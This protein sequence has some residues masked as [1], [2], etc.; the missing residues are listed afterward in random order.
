LHKDQNNLKDLMKRISLILGIFILNFAVTAQSKSEKF[1]DNRN[2]KEKESG[3][4]LW[5]LIRQDN[6]NG[7]FFYKVLLNPSELKRIWENEPSSFSIRIP[8]KGG[9][10]RQMTFIKSNPT[11]TGFC[12]TTSDG[13][14]LIGKEYSGLHYRVSGERDCK[15]AGISFREDGL[16]GLFGLPSCNISIGEKVPG[17]GDYTLSYDEDSKMPAWD[18]GASEMP[19]KEIGKV[20]APSDKAVSPIC[21][22]VRI[23]MEGD[24]D[25]YTKSGNSLTT[26][27]NF[28]TGLF[29]VV[30]QVY[31]NE[32]ISIRLAS[33][34][35]WT[36][37][38]PYVAMT[39]S[40]TVL[41]NFV[42]NRVASTV[43]AD[44]IHLLSTRS[45]YM[46]G[47]AYL[48]VLCNP[49]YKHGFSNIY[50]QYSALPAYSWSVYCIS[51]ELGH[52]FGSNHTQW[53]GWQLT[54][55]KT[56]RI[57]SCYASEG[58]CGTNTK[59]R[60]GTIMSYCHLSSGIDFNKGFGPL[61]Q[62]AIRNGLNAAT[63]ITSSTCMGIPVVSADSLSNKNN[64]YVLS[65]AI[66]AN[67]NASSWK[68]FEG[69]TVIRSGTLSGTTAFNSTVSIS[70]KSNGT[71]SYKMELSNGTSTSVSAVI[72]VVVSVPQAPIAGG[73]CSATGLMAWF[74]TDGKMRFRF[75]ISS[76][77]TTYAVQV[78]RYNLSNSAIIPAAGAVPVA[79]GVRNG[80]TAYSPTASE[81]AQGFIERIADP[82]P[83]NRTTSGLGSFWYS[84]DI[85]CNSGGSCTT[86][87][88]TRTY[89]F[90]PGI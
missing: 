54:S 5:Q 85:T 55:T 2:F 88:R 41:T 27:A 84:V 38:D 8:E 22:P 71:Y 36:T 48:N 87:N 35:Q 14:K 57:D 47:I 24:K 32:G 74:G 65:L 13:R 68:L 26:A 30:A 69:S 53:C 37:A 7:S 9:N 78:C 40:S 21:K 83:A 64:S 90:V 29:N 11:D 61:P 16:M 46:G 62:T 51:H 66:P 18:C 59:A 77:C 20:T 31:Q 33:I 63:C 76:P 80:M 86:T 49:V 15:V 23:Y 75:G 10:I 4:S 79:C 12:I 44:L 45:A 17:S 19:I 89:I 73:I 70:G 58:S 82:Q 28:V 1:S 34:Y 72:N 39:A 67:H 56:G 43:N 60:V 3:K 6:G 52:N 25:L 81:W 42:S 50:Y